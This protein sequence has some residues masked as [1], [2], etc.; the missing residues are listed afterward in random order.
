MTNDEA[1]AW[2]RRRTAVVLFHTDRLV[3]VL[4]HIAAKVE[5]AREVFKLEI[6]EGFVLAMSDRGDSLADVVEAARLC[7]RKRVANAVDILSDTARINLPPARLSF[8][9]FDERFNF[10]KP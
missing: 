4:P 1:I 8:G 3:V 9:E 10:I 7:W 6:K 2:L 5:A